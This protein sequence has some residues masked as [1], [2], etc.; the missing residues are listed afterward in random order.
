MNRMG[1]LA[2]SMALAPCLS[3]AGLGWFE[4]PAVREPPP[5]DAIT[6]ALD[7]ALA[8]AEEPS[9]G[10]PPA[11]VSDALVP[12]LRLEPAPKSAA[13]RFDVSVT[14]M[15]AREFLLG[16]VADTDINLALDPGLSGTITL[17]L[18][19]VTITEVLAALRDVYG[20]AYEKTGYGW[21]VHN[22]GLQSRIF[23]VDYPMVRRSGQSQTR[24]SS[25][26]VSER[27]TGNDSNEIRTE[28]EDVSGSIISTASQSDFWVELEAGLWAI[29]GRN[30]GRSVV[31]SPN[32]GIVVV[33]AMPAELREV[34]RF[35]GRAQASLGRQVILEAK[36]LEVTL[37]DGFQSG[38]NWAL[39]RENG[40]NSGIFAQTG[41]G[42]SLL[43]GLS[44]IAGNV[45][46]LDPSPGPRLPS[47]TD[48]S[49]FGGVFSTALDLE[50]FTAFIELLETQG[51]VRTLSSPRVATVN[52]Q[53]AVIKVGSD[54]F[55]VTDISTTTVT[56]T[57]TTTTPDITLTPFFSGIA[58]DVTP[59]ISEARRDHP[60]HPP[61]DQQ[62]DRPDQDGQRGRRGPDPAAGAL[63]DPG[64]RQ[65]GARGERSGDRARGTDAGPAVPS[66]GGHAMARANS[67]ARR[68]VPPPARRRA[69]HRARDPDA[70]GRGRAG[71]VDAGAAPGGRPHA[72]ARRTSVSARVS[73]ACGRVEP[74]GSAR[75]ISSTSDSRSRRSCSRPTRRSRT[76]TA[77]TA[78]R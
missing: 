51:S 68:A 37:D 13:Q 47:G 11:V 76:S 78:R 49:A 50:D 42:T 58:L 43:D 2:L 14:E 22:A 53:K 6:Q 36:I 62:S 4:P 70:R 35:L 33:R 16:L 71:H 15:P 18:K 9:A 63:D 45:G 66:A 39:L 52:N 55:F 74:L 29:L 48:T 40:A 57:T 31:S 46:D 75:C 8:H 41:G 28:S 26:Q 32:S 65:R 5:P 25:G 1:V 72:L 59:Q 3:C 56:S 19:N 27:V 30:E 67:L 61:L 21:H 7:D 77:A 64:G 38:I 73:G 54:E 23:A 10:A 17:T 34:E 60:A 24:V 69:A 20:Y 44:E 12:P